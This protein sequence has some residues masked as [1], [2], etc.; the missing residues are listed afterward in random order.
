MRVA[1]IGAGVAGL[2]AAYRLGQAG[3]EAHV[4]ER[5]PG[6]GGM[7][8]TFDVGDGVLLERYYHHLFTTDR[9]IADLY[10]ELGHPDEIEH[11]P[12]STAFF[13]DGRLWPF[14][15]PLDLLRFRPLPLL[16]RVRM[17][18]AALRIQ[19]RDDDEHAY[20][21]M[22]ARDWILRNMGRRA[23]DVVWGPLLR[24]KFGHRAE[25]IQMT[26]LWNKLTMRRRLSDSQTKTEVLGYPRHS[27]EL[28]FTRL[29]EEIDRAG[30]TVMIDRPAA[31]VARGDDGGFLVTPGAPESFRRGL[32][33]RAFEPAGDPE[34]YDG[35]VVTLANDLVEQLVEPGLLADPYVERLR[36]IDY[37]AA[38]CLVLVLDREMSPYYW[39]NVTDAGMPFLGLIEHTN[40]VPRERYGGRR[41]VY[42]TNY[43]AP[44]DPVLGMNVDELLDHYE[45]GLRRIRPD[46]SRE[47][48]QASRLFRE[49]HAQPIVDVGYHERIPPLDTGVPGLVVANQSQVYPEDRGTNYAV[50]IG[51]QAAETLLRTAPRAA[52]G[53]LT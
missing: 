38:V 31:R 12:S 20:E 9:E 22:T 41:I 34:R 30:G 50:R 42:V 3:H 39:T 6:L 53:A 28:L 52:R 29:A 11:L 17:G 5:W 32:D 7:A 44:D 33:P 26:W 24:A 4:Y 15:T 2:T 25:D 37:H 14:T 48:I 10:A 19:R 40:Y 49:P 43:V 16:S 1:V 23:W 8:A 18:L 13:T 35:V 36:S 46:F 47:W 45:P 21:G 27:W 51:T